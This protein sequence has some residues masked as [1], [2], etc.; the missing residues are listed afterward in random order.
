MW[1][2][3][4]A[5]GP[6]SGPGGLL[7]D[8]LQLQDVSAPTVLDQSFTWLKIPVLASLLMSSCPH[9]LTGGLCMDQ[10]GK[11]YDNSVVTISPLVIE[12]FLPGS[13]RGTDALFWSTQW[14]PGS[15]CFNK[16]WFF[17]KGAVVGSTECET[18]L[19]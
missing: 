5:T 8:L 6:N 16:D 1:P 3:L 9:N 17:W 19:V 7:P 14:W 10:E 13:L 11:E 4:T 15:S 12:S 2:D 18:S